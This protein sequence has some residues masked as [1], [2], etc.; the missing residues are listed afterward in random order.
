MGIQDKNKKI[1]E[2]KNYPK[3]ETLRELEKFDSSGRKSTSEKVSVDSIQKLAS[4]T[5][6]QMESS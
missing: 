3:S 5:N 2:S 1:I 4:K 6:T